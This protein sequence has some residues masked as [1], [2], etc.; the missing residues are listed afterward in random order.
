MYELTD[1]K[2][3]LMVLILNENAC[4]H[5]NPVDT[6]QSLLR[7]NTELSVNWKSFGFEQN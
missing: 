2:S 4:Q 6:G 5:P 3:R 7:S 1:L